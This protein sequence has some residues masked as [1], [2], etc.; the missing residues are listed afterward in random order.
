M[1]L[2]TAC[3]EELEAFARSVFAFRN[4]LA[5]SF[6]VVSILRSGFLRSLLWLGRSFFFVFCAFVLVIAIVGRSRAL[7]LALLGCCSTT[8]RVSTLTHRYQCGI[9]NLR[10]GFA[11]LLLA[12]N[13]V[14]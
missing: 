14:Q 4:D 6:G 9:A 10:L 11:T 3:E 1:G 12:S 5:S 7:R 8:G 13:G 2:L